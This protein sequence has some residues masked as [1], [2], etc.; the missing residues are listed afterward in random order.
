MWWGTRERGRQHKLQAAGTASPF[1]QGVV[2]ARHG[3]EKWVGHSWQGLFLVNNGS[4]PHEHIAP[5][6]G[7]IPAEVMMMMMMMVQN[8]H[9]AVFS[10]ML[11]AV[12]DT[13]AHTRRMCLCTDMLALQ[14]G[15]MLLCR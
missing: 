6:F 1:A 15:S 7:V 9:N 10:D 13:H 12:G 11:I 14:E 3:H 2:G 8:I 4:G 5:L